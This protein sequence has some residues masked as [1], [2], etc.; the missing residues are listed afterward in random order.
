MPSVKA[1]VS[2]RRFGEEP[3]TEQTGDQHEGHGSEE[4]ARADFQPASDQR[5]AFDGDSA[6][7][8][9]P[10][11]NT[12]RKPQRAHVSTPKLI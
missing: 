5:L 2:T 6:C 11:E 12:R 8:H 3:R 9:Q 4:F 10:T 1:T 7:A